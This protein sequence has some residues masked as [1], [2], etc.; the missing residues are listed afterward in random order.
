MRLVNIGD[1]PYLQ[2]QIAEA[3]A[4][5]EHHAEVA[6]IYSISAIHGVRSTAEAHMLP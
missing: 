3:D 6:A 2:E 1:A 4:T 5:P